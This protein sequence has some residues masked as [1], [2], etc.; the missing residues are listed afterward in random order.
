M[1][2]ES[3]DVGAEFSLVMDTARG[4]L[5]L[6]Q[7]LTGTRATGKL[8]VKAQAGRVVTIPRNRYLYPIVNSKARPD[9]LFKTD[10]APDDCGKQWVVDDGGG[11]VDILSNIG[12][13][14]HNLPLGTKFAFDP[15]APYAQPLPE[16]S[17]ATVGGVD[18]VGF[19]SL[20]DAVVYESMEG[21]HALALR[22]SMTKAFPAAVLH[23]MAILPPEGSTSAHAGGM[24]RKGE[25]RYLYALKYLLTV[26]SSRA[27]ED[28]HR[29]H[30][31]L[32]IVDRIF[33]LLPGRSAVDGQS[34][35]NPMPVSI[36]NAQ[37]EQLAGEDY[38][39]FYAYNMLVSCEGSHVSEP[40]G[41]SYAD[42][43]TT[44]LTSTKPP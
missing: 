7:P 39:R 22:R 37:R 41:R 16:L 3:V 17:Q 18:A 36:L 21:D 27:D 24:R 30:E 14:R 10:L 38:Q 8:L 11:E 33:G 35:S 31:G 43:L 20:K 42:W 40:T 6:L 2:V 34:V 12:G 13:A 9:L 4:L 32:V 25:W 29:R 23:W 26:V 44:S 1:P 28:N 19:G 5:A 15:P